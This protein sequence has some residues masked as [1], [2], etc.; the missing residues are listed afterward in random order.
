MA[1]TKDI[2]NWLDDNTGK[3]EPPKPSAKG[4]STDEIDAFLDDKA[5]APPS[6]LDK[7]KSLVTSHIPAI[8]E[9]AGAVVDPMTTLLQKAPDM[10]HRAA[11]F[12][13]GN[14]NTPAQTPLEAMGNRPDVTA[15]VGASMIP[16]GGLAGAA[17]RIL[18]TAA[19]AA[20]NPEERGANAGAAGGLQAVLEALPYGA[21]KFAPGIRAIMAKASGVEADAIKKLFDN[22]SLL[23]TGPNMREARALYKATA[24][25]IGLNSEVSDEVLFQSGKR[26]VKNVLDSMKAGEEIPTQTLLDARQATSDLIESSKRLGK[27]N[28]MKGF[29]QR[30]QDINAA[31]SKQAPE[32]RVADKTFSQAATRDQFFNVLPMNQNGTPSVAKAVIGGVAGAVPAFAMSPL[33]QGVGTS[34]AGAVAQAG[35]V[36]KSGI[37]VLRQYL[38]RQRTQGPGSR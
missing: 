19:G 30:Y 10:A 1:S 31:I 23:W 16:G 37:Q 25:K 26:F 20:L 6:L 33:V 13:Q 9:V 12:V 35:P 36:A 29:T 24:E 7:A 17:A 15:Q 3:V 27:T 32:L 5:P 4:P 2:D 11:N 28:K 21:G 38:E 22:P 34:A 18:G 14:P 8:K